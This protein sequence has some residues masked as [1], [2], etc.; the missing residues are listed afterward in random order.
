MQTQWTATVLT[1]NN[2]LGYGGGGSGG[3]IGQ[4]TGGVGGG[5]GGNG[6]VMI[7]EF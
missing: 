7:T 6:V 2:A 4:A 1:G 3:S 5:N